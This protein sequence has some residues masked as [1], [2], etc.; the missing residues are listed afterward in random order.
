MCRTNR[1]CP[2]SRGRNAGGLR[3]ARD[4]YTTKVLALSALPE[5]VNAVSRA[6]FS[7]DSLDFIREAT[8]GKEGFFEMARARRDIAAEALKAVARDPLYVVGDEPAI[9]AVGVYENWR[10][11]GHME[12]APPYHLLDTATIRDV[13]RSCEE[14]VKQAHAVTTDK[15]RDKAVR[16]YNRDADTMSLH[17]LTAFGGGTGSS[18]V[19]QDA[20]DEL[21]FGSGHL[22]TPLYADA[23]AAS[24][25]SPHGRDVRAAEHW[26]GR[27]GVDP[28]QVEV[29]MS[30]QREIVA[31][32]GDPDKDKALNALI[33]REWDGEGAPNARELNERLRAVSDRNADRGMG[34]EFSRADRDDSEWTD[35]RAGAVRNALFNVLEDEASGD[36]FSSAAKVG[37]GDKELARKLL[38]GDEATVSD[39][40]DEMLR[41]GELPAGLRG[42]EGE[43]AIE[44]RAVRRLLIDAGVHPRHAQSK[45]LPPAAQRRVKDVLRAQIVAAGEAMYSDD[46]YGPGWRTRTLEERAD[47]TVKDL[48]S[49]EPDYSQNWRTVHSEIGY[50]LTE[51]ATAAARARREASPAPESSMDPLF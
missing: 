43:R 33:A 28:G 12:T 14:A 18:A 44:E 20:V 16:M 1:R 19:L 45:W 13:T 36:I 21:K 17:S 40:G 24:N 34:V 5:T 42:G 23:L 51:A 30:P 47:L 41:M 37:A 7:N 8:P 26:L 11:N 9:G 48:F 31:K 25:V 10:A 39:F 32:T 35:V 29:V 46:D 15:E 27:M 22:P 6:S 38:S 50:V 3:P 2:S 4:S 49:E